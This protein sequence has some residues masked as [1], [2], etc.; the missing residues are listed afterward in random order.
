MIALSLTCQWKDPA[1]LWLVKF[2]GLSQSGM[3]P[4]TIQLVEF[5]LGGDS[6]DKGARLMLNV[7]FWIWFSLYNY[8]TNSGPADSSA[9][10]KP[11]MP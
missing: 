8:W 4:N 2:Y 6:A 11:I 7:E 9:G 3:P 10:D 1:T 5:E